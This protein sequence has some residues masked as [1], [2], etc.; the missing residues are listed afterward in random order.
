MKK[1]TFCLVPDSKN[2][3]DQ[4]STKEAENDIG[5]G[6]PGVQLHEP[7]GAQVQ[8]LENPE[9]THTIQGWATDV[10]QTVQCADLE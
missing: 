2:P 4:E 1:S 10:K 9:K 6:V 7:C 8:V 3:V 5:P